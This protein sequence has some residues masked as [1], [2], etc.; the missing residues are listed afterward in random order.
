MKKLINMDGH[1]TFSIITLK[2]V[3][4]LKDAIDSLIKNNIHKLL[5]DCANIE[6]L[7]RV[8]ILGINSK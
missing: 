1:L 2:A 4:K 8:R 6:I 7:E 5:D 3:E